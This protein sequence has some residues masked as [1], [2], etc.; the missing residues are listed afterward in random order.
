MTRTA[1]AA[2][3]VLLALALSLSTQSAQAVTEAKHTQSYANCTA[4]HKRYAHGVG[5]LGAHDHV[6][7]GIPVKNFKVSTTLYNQNKSKDRD[8]DGIACEKL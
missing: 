8:H 5:R 3:L 4:L 6:T 2:A 7:S 1:A